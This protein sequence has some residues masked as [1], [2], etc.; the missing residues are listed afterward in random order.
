M[1]EDLAELLNSNGFN[2]LNLDTLLDDIF[3]NNGRNF[4]LKRLREMK[5]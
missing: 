4:M 3:Y 5:G 1:R 2:S